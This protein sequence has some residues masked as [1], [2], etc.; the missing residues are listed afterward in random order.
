MCA[1]GG[2]S[3]PPEDASRVRPATGRRLLHR[4]CHWANDERG[5]RA[6]AERNADWPR[7]LAISDLCGE[8]F[9][10][11]D[12]APGSSLRQWISD[13]SVGRTSRAVC[14]R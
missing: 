1:A 6:R 13:V 7:L 8:K 10:V 3:R 14:A 2:R 9:L 4:R 5:R 12:G 11:R